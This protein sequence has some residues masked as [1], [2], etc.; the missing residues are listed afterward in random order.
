MELPD[1]PELDKKQ[2]LRYEKESTGMYFSGHP[3]EEYADKIKKITKYNIGD[4]LSRVQN[5]GEYIKADGGLNDGDKITL[6]AL[7]EARKNKITRSNSQMAFL[8]LEDSM[9]SI[10][11]L[12]FP[13]VLSTY[14]VILQENEI[15]CID[16]TVSL[17]EDEAPKFI[18]EGAKPIND[19]LKIK[20]SSQPKILYIKLSSKTR[21]NL[22]LAEEALAPYQGET[23]VRLF[24]EDT[25]KMASVPRK[26]WFNESEAALMDLK[27]IFGENNVRIK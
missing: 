14:S 24:F 26:L 19:A 1:I 13:K 20:L 2:R 6:C 22:R 15:V 16:G 9:G 7:I 25:K 3:M 23:E 10:E 4:I 21:E 12:V 18:A 27:S 11:C 17:R 5:D 8:T